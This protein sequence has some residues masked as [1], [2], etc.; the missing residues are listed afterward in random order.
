MYRYLTGDL[1]LFI[2]KP[3]FYCQ[4]SAFV[5]RVCAARNV[6]IDSEF[7]AFCV[8][9]ASKVVLRPKREQDQ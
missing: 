2:F 4:Q 6:D 3:F 7:V 9:F 5:G 1:I 8:V